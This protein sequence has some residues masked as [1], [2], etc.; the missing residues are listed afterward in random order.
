M[1]TE[2]ENERLILEAAEAEFL[3]KGYNGAKTTSI[4]RRAGVTHA[5]LHYYYRT[6][7]NLFDQVFQSKVH[8]ITDSFEQ[9][10]NEPMPFG[11][12]ITHF[13]R[14]H[15]NFIRHNP[16]LINFMYNEVLTNKENRD[17]LYHS[18]FPI[19]QKVYSKVEQLINEEVEKGNIRPVKALDLILNIASM[20]VLT[21]MTYPVMKEYI[22]VTDNE[23]YE[24]MLKEREESNIQFILNSLRK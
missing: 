19:L 2:S 11:E 10:L 17:M 8:V 22:P 15:F 9:I 23:M 6:K 13:I 3:E 21:F 14:V 7:E 5:M 12:A 24:R 16:R 1:K 4:A 20:N 18:V